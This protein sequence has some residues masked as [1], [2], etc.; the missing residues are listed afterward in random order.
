MAKEETMLQIEP[1]WQQY[2][3]GHGYHRI[4]PYEETSRRVRPNWVS[5]EV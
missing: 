4:E 3:R 2:L 1:C 5:K